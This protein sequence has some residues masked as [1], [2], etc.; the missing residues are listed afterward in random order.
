M[1]I[2]HDVWNTQQWTELELYLVIITFLYGNLTTMSFSHKCTAQN[3]ETTSTC[4]SS[5]NK[6]IAENDTLWSNVPYWHPIQNRTFQLQQK[7]TDRHCPQATTM[8]MAPF[9]TKMCGIS[10]CRHHKTF[11]LSKYNIWHRIQKY[12]SIHSTHM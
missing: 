7:L 2:V 6:N 5:R 4:N 8:K 3:G 10:S 11:R 9:C 12:F 1:G